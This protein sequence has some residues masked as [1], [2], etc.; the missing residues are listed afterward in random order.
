[1]AK[2]FAMSKIKEALSASKGDKKNWENIKNEIKAFI[3][4]ETA[5]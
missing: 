2:N 3:D 5:D 4:K 1:M